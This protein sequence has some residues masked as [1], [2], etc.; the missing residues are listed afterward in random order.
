MRRLVP[1][2]CLL[3][4]LAMGVAGFALWAVERPQP[5]I[6]L[7]RARVS[8]DQQYRE[9]LEAQLQRQRWTRNLVLGCLFAGSG[10]LTVIAFLTMEPA[11]RRR[12][13]A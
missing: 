6:D 2:L 13:R 5:G 11:E 8:G 7:H 3:L 12:N 4:A 1:P 10:G 9:L